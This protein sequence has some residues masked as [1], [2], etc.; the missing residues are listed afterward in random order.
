M[1]MIQ[2]LFYTSYVIC[3]LVFNNCMGYLLVANSIRTFV[4]FK[5]KRIKKKVQFTPK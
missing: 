4:R 3:T 5:K 1:Y 2:E